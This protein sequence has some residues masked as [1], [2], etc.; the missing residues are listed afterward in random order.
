M[1]TKIELINGKYY[2]VTYDENENAIL[3]VLIGNHDDM[4][5]QVNF[6][7]K[8]LKSEVN[9]LN[10]QIK[11]LKTFLH[12]NLKNNKDGFAIIDFDDIDTF[13]KLD[14]NLLQI[15]NHIKA[16][17]KLTNDQNIDEV[18]VQIESEKKSQ[19]N[20]DINFLKKSIDALR[21]SNLKSFYF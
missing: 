5:Y 3:M 11:T 19:N 2:D 12:N 8:E 17:K 16:N 9:D 4:L 10:C 14:E 7:S 18:I 20:E 6:R 1:K 21:Y 15:K 13:Q